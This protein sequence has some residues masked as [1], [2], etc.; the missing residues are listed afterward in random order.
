MDLH[1]E[2]AFLTVV[3]HVRLAGPAAGGATDGLMMCCAGLAVGSG[4]PR[5]TFRQ[6]VIVIHRQGKSAPWPTSRYPSEI[7]RQIFR[8]S[9]FNIRQII[10]AYSISSAASPYLWLSKHTAACCISSSRA[11]RSGVVGMGLCAKIMKR[12]WSFLRVLFY[13]R[14]KWKLNNPIR[15][16]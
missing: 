9:R 3:H 10:A 15:N 6:G 13:N 14:I 2:E 5:A 12:L 16:T 11:V 4:S 7:S 8:N 1:K